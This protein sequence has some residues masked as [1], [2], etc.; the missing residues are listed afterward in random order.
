M[1]EHTPEIGELVDVD[2]GDGVLRRAKV[3]GFEMI[4][5]PVVEYPAPTGQ[6]H[7][8]YCRSVGKAPEPTRETVH[9]D[10]IVVDA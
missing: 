8:L 7:A 6:L 5:C 2:Q 9:P 3:V 4:R 10:D 1:T